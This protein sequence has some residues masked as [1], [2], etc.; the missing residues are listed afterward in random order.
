MA[1]QKIVKE[2]KAEVEKISETEA[3]VAILKRIVEKE[4]K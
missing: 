1:K 2:E 4:S 3:E